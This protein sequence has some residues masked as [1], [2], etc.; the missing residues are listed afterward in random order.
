[1]KTQDN[2][3][4][5]SSSQDFAILNPALIHL[6][7]FIDFFSQ[8]LVPKHDTSVFWG[9]VG[10]VIKVS[11]INP[12]L[13]MSNECPNLVTKIAQC[14]ESARSRIPRMLRDICHEFEI[15]NGYCSITQ[16]LT[17]QI[18]E[19]CLESGLEL[20]DFLSETVKFLRSDIIDS[21]PS[22]FYPSLSSN[23]EF[24]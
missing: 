1:M 14:E 16:T 17:P 6:R 3:P 2:S 21:T 9:M 10:L 24:T 7:T 11:I 4:H 13:C 15:V 18:E 22:K 8:Q 20:L 12:P 5:Q 23:L 19:A